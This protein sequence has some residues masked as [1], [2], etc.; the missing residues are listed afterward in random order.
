MKVDRFDFSEQTVCSHAAQADMLR[1]K[2]GVSTLLI[3]WDASTS[4]R[5]IGG[6]VARDRDGFSFDLTRLTLERAKAMGRALLDKHIPGWESDESGYG[7]I[8]IDL[9]KKVAVFDRFWREGGVGVLRMRHE[10][11]VHDLS[12][13]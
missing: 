9:V 3:G 5:K 11:L 10:Q 4:G 6:I 7:D 13:R 2:F 1:E 8:S 12:E